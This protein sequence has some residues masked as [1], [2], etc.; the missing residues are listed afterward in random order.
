MRAKCLLTVSLLLGAARA[1]AAEHYVRAGIAA[2][3]SGADWANAYPVLPA[4]LIR[5]DTYYVAGGAY[6][7]HVFSDAESGTATITIKKATQSDH[8]LDSGWQPSFGTAQA[9]FDS[10][11]R[12]TR[13]HYVLDGGARNEADWFD[14]AGYGMQIAAKN[15]DQNIII[16]D[17]VRAVSDVIVRYVYV[18]A[19]VGNLPNMTIR[20]L[21]V[22][23]DTY[24]GPINTGLKFSRMFVN[25]SNNVW[26]LRSTRGGIVEY[27]ASSGA[28]GNSANHG[29]NRQR[30]FQRLCCHNSI[31]QV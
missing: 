24:G 25:G 18:N 30:L 1:N 16:G 7:S 17:Q 20:R 5:G 8:G 15:Q 22:D 10:A 13:G 21:A 29:G 27:S 3:L 26:F 12:F 2:G 23:T 4:S 11:L 6:P 14:G 28:A 9:V 19:I 31:Q